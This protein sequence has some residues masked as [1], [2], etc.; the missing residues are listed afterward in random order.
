MSKAYIPAMRADRVMTNPLYAEYEGLILGISHAE[1]GIAA[2]R[3]TGNWAN[4]AVS[5]QDIF[6][7]YKTLEYCIGKYWEK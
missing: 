5:S 1:V 7:N 4:L 3:M 2:N 6:Y